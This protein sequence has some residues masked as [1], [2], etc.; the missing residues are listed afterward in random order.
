[1]ISPLSPQN[2]SQ[3]SPFP[4]FPSQKGQPRPNLGSVDEAMA[5]M[6]IGHTD[7]PQGRMGLGQGRGRGPAGPPQNRGPPP[8]RGGY[9]YTDMNR[10]DS[11]HSD[12]SA[13]S[14]QRPPPRG[15]PQQRPP[16]MNLEGVQRPPQ[17]QLNP[18]SPTQRAF[19]PNTQRSM[20]MPQNMMPGANG[21]G[22][23]SQQQHQWVGPGPVAGYHGPESPDYVPPRPATASGTKNDGR[24]Q[25]FEQRAPMPQGPPSQQQQY[26][27]YPQ[28]EDRPPMPQV[29]L[30]QPQG[31]WQHQ[32]YQDD[33][34][35]DLDNLYDDYYGDDARR[36]SKAT[37][38]DMPNFDAIPETGT[39]HRRGFSIENHL[40]PTALTSN[41]QGSDATA[42]PT[43]VLNTNYHQDQIY[44]QASRSRSQPDLHEQ[45][46]QPVYEMAGDAPAVPPL[47]PATQMRPEERGFVDPTRPAPNGLPNGLRGRGPPPRGMTMDAV[48]N[49][50]PPGQ[51]YGANKQ[52]NLDPRSRPQHP[53][54]HRGY[55][56]ES[57]YSE[58]GPNAMR[59]GSPMAPANVIPRPGTAAPAP[60]R[61]PSDPVQRRAG[62]KPPIRNIDGTSA[63]TIAVSE[64][65]SPAR[66]ET[67]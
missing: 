15:Y 12:G 24:Q 17:R 29:P 25:Q 19:G 10:H 26:Q 20:T 48:S 39:K 40:S 22:S 49:R 13:P 14:Q 27:Q 35:G 46:S 9:G 6:S 44:Q 51:P 33:G 63:N 67:L 37:S 21:R 45:Y 5:L 28:Y 23:D 34:R 50:G 57:A 61:M 52:S 43:P 4:S 8:G 7:E 54:V 1:M 53:P 55:S 66:H 62:I 16:P 65:L 31:S 42:G 11:G 2:F 59:M 60:S 64:P 30:N 38:I 41:M 3:N 36:G 47:P 56:G 32:Q 18:T 58:P